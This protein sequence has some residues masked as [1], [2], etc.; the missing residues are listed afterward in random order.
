MSR[1]S[2]KSIQRIKEI[3]MS[4]LSKY[5]FHLRSLMIKRGREIGIVGLKMRLKGRKLFFYIGETYDING[6][7]EKDEKKLGCKRK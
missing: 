6:H 1:S 4:S 3:K 2:V 7:K 5:S